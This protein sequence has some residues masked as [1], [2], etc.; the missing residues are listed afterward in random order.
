MS[1]R[2]TYSVQETCELLG[3]SLQL[4][5]WVVARVPTDWHHRDPGTQ[6]RGLRG[7]DRSVA[8][9]IAHLVVYEAD[10]AN[11]V[12]RELAHGRD[13]SAVAKSGSMSW[14]VPKFIELSKTPLP[15]LVELLHEARSRQIEIVESFDEKTFNLPMTALWSTGDGTRLESPG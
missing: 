1:V 3:R 13:G 8:V 2:Q 7:D 11:P 14:R 5:D 10:L 4:L 15:K 12:L 6:I 9:H